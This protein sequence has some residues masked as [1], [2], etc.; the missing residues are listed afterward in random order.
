[1]NK[2]SANKYG[3]IVVTYNRLKLLKECLNNIFNQ[4]YNFSKIIIIDNNSNDGTKDFLKGIKQE[5]KEDINILCLDK[6]IGGAGGFSTGVQYCIDN[7]QKELD[8]LLLIDDDAIIDLKFIET[9]NHGLDDN[10]RAYSGTVITSGNID[11]SHRRNIV[12]NITMRSKPVSINEYRKDNFEYELGSFCGLV[13]SMEVVSKVAPP[14][15]DFFIWYDD[16]EYS[17]RIGKYTRIKNINNAIIDH[18]TNKDVAG[19]ISWKSF[20]GYRNFY[21]IGRSYSNKKIIFCLYRLSFHVIK[22]LF[23]LFMSCANFGK[24][25]IRNYYQNIARLHLDVIKA[26][27]SGETGVDK[28]YIPGFKI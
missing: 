23:S 15:Q 13:V 4:T 12:G 27:L 26:V 25:E 6:N 9:I 7:F 10:H 18:K 19:K 2:K 21:Y 20:Y 28:K 11:V 17:Y 22:L 14:R 24:K 5:R 1:M 16:T 3:V 8:Y